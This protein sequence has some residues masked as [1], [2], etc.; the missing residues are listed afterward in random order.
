MYNEAERQK[1]KNKK[2]KLLAF[3]AYLISTTWAFS[4]TNIPIVL[5]QAVG[6]KSV[7]CC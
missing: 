7:I 4:Q 6:R 5:E 2:K 1:Y 3:V